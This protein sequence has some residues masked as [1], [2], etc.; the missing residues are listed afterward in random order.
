VD[1]RLQTVDRRS[2]VQDPVLAL[3]LRQTTDIFQFGL[4]VLTVFI[5]TAGT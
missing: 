4:L 5:L 1:E 3:T 2:Q